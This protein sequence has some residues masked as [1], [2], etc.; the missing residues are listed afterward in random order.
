M[1]L[2]ALQLPTE[3]PGK[4]ECYDY[5][6]AT[7]IDHARMPHP[8][9]GLPAHPY[10]V[11]EQ[12]DAATEKEG[13]E[14]QTASARV[15]IS[16]L[17]ATDQNIDLNNGF[18]LAGMD[19]Q[20]PV[21]WHM[22]LQE[23]R[24]GLWVRSS[25]LLFQRAGRETGTSTRNGNLTNGESDCLPTVSVEYYRC[26]LSP[27]KSHAL[28]SFSDGNSGGVEMQQSVWEGIA[29]VIDFQNGRYFDLCR[30]V[31]GLKTPREKVF[32]VFIGQCG[33]RQLRLA[34]SAMGNTNPE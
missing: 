34:P 17:N 7:E 30:C 5:S 27:G 21:R 20:Y 29:L 13:D 31:P 2:K 6:H 8:I 22:A 16:L 14:R 26:N 10:A 9:E 19:V 24:N 11:E 3:E 12:S 1:S 32:A 18:R 25:R 28:F 4:G 23:H 33:S 15:P